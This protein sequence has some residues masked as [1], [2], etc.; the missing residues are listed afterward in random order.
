[1]GG[2]RGYHTKWNKSD[3]ERHISYDITYMW[4]SKNNDANDLIY[5]VEIDSQT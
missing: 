2:S 3:V 5:K 4:E 1:M